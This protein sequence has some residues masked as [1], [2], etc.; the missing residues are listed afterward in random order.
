MAGL[1]SA[2]DFSG[3]RGLLTKAVELKD[4]LLK[5]FDTPSGFPYTNF[6]FENGTPDT[7]NPRA[8]LA[9]IGSCQMEFTRLSIITGDN[10]I[11]KQ[12]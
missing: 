4:L 2:Y 9:T 5:Y 6:D 7:S 12:L 10:N 3:D 8:Y 11:W 1:I